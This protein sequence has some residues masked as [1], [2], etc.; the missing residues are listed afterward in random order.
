MERVGRQPPALARGFSVH[1]FPQAGQEA[2]AA[3][4]TTVPLALGQR[5]L[6]LDLAQQIAA[7]ARYVPNP[8]EVGE[9]QRGRPEGQ[10]PFHRRPHGR[11]VELGGRD[12]GQDRGAAIHIQLAQGDAEGLASEDAATVGIEQAQVV[13]G[14][15]GG[16][17]THQSAATEVE[18][19]AI[20][21]GEDALDRHR[22]QLTVQPLSLVRAIDGL[23]GGEQ[24]RRVGHVPRPARMHHQPG[25]GKGLH[26]RPGPAGVIQMDVGQEDVIDAGR[27]QSQAPQGVQYPR[28]AG[29]GGGVHHGDPAAFDEEIDRGELGAEV[30]GVHGVNTGFI[31]QQFDHGRSG[32]TGRPADGSPIPTG[33]PPAR[34]GSGAGSFPERRALWII[35]KIPIQH[36][37][38]HPFFGD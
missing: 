34:S 22:R 29:V 31:T 13:T 24:R 30:A 6:R 2:R 9:V 8:A 26:H 19:M 5:H 27:R 4:R 36:G 14:V 25:F 16:V 21:G 3:L 7:Q 38:F 33:S 18:G 10:Q 17:K 20:A 12:G 32:N 1:P 37:V 35:A 28:Q 11:R 23:D 15:A